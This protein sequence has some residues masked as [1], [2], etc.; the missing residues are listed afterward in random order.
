VTEQKTPESL[1]LSLSLALLVADA[2]AFTPVLNELR[3]EALV[4]A[5]RDV[6]KGTVTD[7]QEA[8][9]CDRF[10]AL[11]CQITASYDPSFA[12]QNAELSA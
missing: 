10:I 11:G 7:E 9:W 1:S 5:L 12:E 3:R 4:G 2:L 6:A 8:R